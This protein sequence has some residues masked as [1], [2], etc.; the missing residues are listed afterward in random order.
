MSFG[1]WLKRSFMNA[2]K[3]LSLQNGLQIY[4]LWLGG[5]SSHVAR[6]TNYHTPCGNQSLTRKW[7]NALISK[8]PTLPLIWAY[9]WA[10]RHK[11][12]I[13]NKMTQQMLGQ[14]PMS[15]PPFH[16]SFSPWQGSSMTKTF[17]Y[18][19]T[20]VRYAFALF[21]KESVGIVCLSVEGRRLLHRLWHLGKGRK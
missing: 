8:S 19:L 2:W 16:D 5:H 7:T 4:N 15:L 17:G 18:P 6:G 9:V 12:N 10:N 11:I 1:V 14:L 3:F 21:N 13:E 20:L